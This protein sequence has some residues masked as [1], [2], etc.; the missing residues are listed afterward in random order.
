MAWKNTRVRHSKISIGYLD[1]WLE[2][3]PWN[4]PSIEISRAQ[5]CNRKILSFS[6]GLM[7]LCPEQA[8]DTNFPATYL[9]S[10]TGCLV[11]LYL[12]D[13][14]APT[15]SYTP[16]LNLRWRPLPSLRPTAASR[17]TATRTKRVKRLR[18][19]PR[20]SIRILYYQIYLFS[21]VNFARQL[22]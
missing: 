13:S 22:L 10:S 14:D 8:R 20:A 6:G 21:D 17:A 15:G 9:S 11:G 7:N 1:V 19:M 2:V 16:I 5:Q 18:V 4:A 3:Y 12:D